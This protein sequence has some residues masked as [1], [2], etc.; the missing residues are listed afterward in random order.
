[1]T[2]IDRA[3]RDTLS[4]EDRAFIERLEQE[5]PLHRQIGEMFR[6]RMRWLN[7]TGWILALVLFGTA[8]WCGWRFVH[9]TEIREMLLW[10]AA[11]TLAVIGL[12][13]VKIWMWM[14]LHHNNVMREIKRMELLIASRER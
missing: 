10:G 2:D 7:I 9:A 13:A 3:I 4:S 11:G 8:C 14:Q 1:M 5:P 6:G 12:T